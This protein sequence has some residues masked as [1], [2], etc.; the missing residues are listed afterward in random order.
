M[1]IYV[2]TLTYTHT[3]ECMLV[4]TH[5]SLFF[6]RISFLLYMQRKFT[7]FKIIAL[8]FIDIRRFWTLTHSCFPLFYVVIFYASL[9]RLSFLSLSLCL[10][11]FTHNMNE[12]K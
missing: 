12:P 6:S 1:A 4:C 3:I 8:G 11:F 10:C 2:Q 7:C 9:S 5:K